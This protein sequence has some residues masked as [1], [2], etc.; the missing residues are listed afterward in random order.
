MKG[1]TVTDCPIHLEVC[2]PSCYWFSEGRCI[3][4][5]YHKG[6]FCPYRLGVF[7]Q[8]EYCSDC[9][10]WIELFESLRR[11][12]RQCCAVLSVDTQ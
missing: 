8:E 11:G 5:Q 10:I 1:I 3:A 12:G 7:C 4:P 9:Q 2:Y 6:E